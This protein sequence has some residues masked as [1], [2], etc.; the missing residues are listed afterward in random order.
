MLDKLQKRICR[1]AG[2]MLGV[3]LEP[4]THC[5][6]VSSL[7]LFYPVFSIAITL[8]DV[9]PNLLNWSHFLILEEGILFILLHCMIFCH[10]S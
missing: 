2:A 7:S 4:L 3:S 9:H 10:H 5:Q 8:V 1:T 6:N